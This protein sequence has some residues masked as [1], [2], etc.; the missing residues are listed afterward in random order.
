MIKLK[1]I[2]HYD[3]LITLDI[4][5]LAVTIDH[6]QTFLI[7]HTE[8]IHKI[9]TDKIKI[10]KKKQII[11]D[12]TNYK[13]KNSLPNGNIFLKPRTT[14][15]NIKITITIKTN[16]LDRT[17]RAHINRIPQH[18]KN[19]ENTNNY[20]RKNY[21]NASTKRYNLDQLPFLNGLRQ[22]TN[23]QTSDLKYI[24]L[25]TQAQNETT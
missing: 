12:N 3:T 5:K 14:R 25:T 1:T 8:L 15:I 24:S 23:L 21:L 10:I 16:E 6:Q 11:N 17:K 13:H 20:Y 4:E 7:H 9:Q 22:R 2:D 18:V 19:Y